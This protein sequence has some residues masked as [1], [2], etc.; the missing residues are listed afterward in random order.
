MRCW[1]CGK[2]LRVKAKHCAYCEAAVESAPKKE[3]IEAVL[4]FMK[5]FP[6]DAMEELLAAFE[7]SKTAEEFADHILVGQCPNC[8]SMDVGNCEAD[9]EIEELL[10]GRCFQ[11][12]QLWCTECR[13][14]LER[15]SPTCA[16]WIE[17]D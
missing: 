8:G 1:N 3:E 4:E 12:G 5:E 16:C 17:D 10:V 9:P 13:R 7:G 6:P 2:R 15:D 11:C 14:L